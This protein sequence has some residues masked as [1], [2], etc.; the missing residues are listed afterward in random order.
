MEAGVSERVASRFLP[1]G[2]RGQ[3]P[4]GTY[5]PRFLSCH[6]PAHP[7]SDIPFRPPASTVRGCDRIITIEAGRIVEDGTHDELLR[8]G[9]RYASLQDSKGAGRVAF[10]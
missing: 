3:H 1:R 2:L 6:N 7:R 8:R 4:T 5:R 9:G 10:P